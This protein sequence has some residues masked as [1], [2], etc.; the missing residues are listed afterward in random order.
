MHE[1]Q[2]PG[3]IWRYA[4]GSIGSGVY[5]TVPSVLLL[6][7]L[8]DTVGLPPLLAGLVLL[9][10]KL[11]GVI[12][13][14]LIGSISDRTVTPLGRRTPFLI[15]GTIGMML[16]F[17]VLFHT[18]DT[19]PIS[20]R[21]LIALLAYLSTSLCYSM[22][23]VPYINMPAE[24]SGDDAVRTKL[25]ALRM[26]F[27]FL[28]TI[29]GAALPPLLVDSFGGGSAG[30]GGMAFVIIGLT[31][32][33]MLLAAHA[34]FQLES[35]PAAKALTRFSMTGLF[36]PLGTPEF[37]QLLIVYVLLMISSAATTSAIPYLVVH[38]L[39][40][41]ESWIGY[42]LL[43]ALGTATICAP[44][45][46]ALARRLGRAAAFQ[47]AI[48]ATIIGGLLLWA[49]QDISMLILFAAAFFIGVGASGVQVFSFALLAGHIAKKGSMGAATTGLWTGAEKLGLAIGPAFTALSLWYFA[50][51]GT[52]DSARDA[53]SQLGIW[54]AVC[55]TPIVVSVVALI[56]LA[57]T[58][59]H[60]DRMP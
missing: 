40:L 16:S 9:L 46:P 45:W 15:F 11:L 43:A 17:G 49:S 41:R 3:R 56:L 1:N 53:P 52:N 54:V 31:L 47:T 50:L 14:P 57:R 5:A 22:F 8:T 21:F 25:I 44:T 35:R 34:T 27:V 23:A 6:Y 30:Y 39:G 38:G 36:L 19:G 51:A 33:V 26:A 7:Y 10:P 28:G 13:D 32:P 24:I 60:Q 2:P 20:S 55:V 58:L 12:V 59:P 37:R 4:A 29:I 48:A 18:P 42:V